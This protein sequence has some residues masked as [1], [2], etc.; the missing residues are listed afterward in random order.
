MCVCVCLY[1]Y[2]YFF[3]L[4]AAVQFSRNLGNTYYVTECILGTESQNIA[5]ALPS[6]SNVEIGLSTN[7]FKPVL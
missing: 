4:A 5:S 6:Q 1:V 7:N 3:I 2:I